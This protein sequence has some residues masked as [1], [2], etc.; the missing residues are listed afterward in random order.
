LPKVEINIE[1]EDLIILRLS[2]AGYGTP[3]QIRQMTGQDVIS[4]YHYENFIND[5]EKE[6]FEINKGK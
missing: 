3:E 2:K 4:L 6:F 5:Y 1:N